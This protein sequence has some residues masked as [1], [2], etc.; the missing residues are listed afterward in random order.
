MKADEA[1]RL[2]TTRN[3]GIIAHI[4]AG[5]TT[6]SERILYYTGRTYKIGEV[7]DGAAVMDWMEQE[8][9]R[10]ITIT[11][12]A[13]TCQ[14][15]DCTINLIDTPGHVDFTVEV[16][17]SLRVL[18][19]AVGVFCAVGGVEP[20]SETVWRQGDTYKVPRLAF[21]NKMD[22]VGADFFRVLEMMKARLHTNP[23]PFQIPIGKEENFL[24]VIDLI[25]MKATYYDEQSLGA[26][27][28]EKDIPADMLP[29]ATE[30]RE[31]LVESIVEHDDEMMHHYLEG[32]EITSEE[33]MHAARAATLKL[34]ITPVLCGA[35]FKNKGV[36]H[37]LDAVVDYL[38]SPLDVPPVI[39]MIPGKEEITEERKASSEEPFTALAFKI[40]TDPYVGQLTYIRI[41][42]GELK[43]GTHIYNVRKSKKERV[44]R[45]LRMHSNKREEIESAA[46]GEI[47]AVLGLKF[48]TT[49]DT[50]TTEEHPITLESLMIPEPVIS[51]AVEPKT[52]DD[53][54]KMGMALAKLAVEDPSLRVS[55]D[56]ESGQTILAGMGEL[57]L[58]IIV[59]RMKREFGIVA[60]IGKPQ[61]AYRETVM[62][63][64]EA[65]YKHIKQSGGRGQYGHVWLKVENLG[66]GS[67]FE[68]ENGVVG[69]SIPR[70]YIPAV[71]KGVKEGMDSGGLAGYPMVDVKVTVFDGSYHDVD[72]SEI[73]FK[74]AGLQAFRK[75]CSAA[76]PILLEPIMKVD[77][78]VPDE[79]VGAVTGD[80]SGRRGHIIH[81]ER[82]GNL[83]AITSHIPLA[84]MFG[85]ATDVR[86]V[87]QG[88]ATY[89]M[90]FLKYQ[91][92]P[93]NISEEV[94]KKVKGT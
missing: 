23:V 51:I 66:K 33:V 45:M 26:T 16:E 9:E 14:W 53:Q 60:N 80:I 61:V 47:V 43:A 65:E 32:G 3:I 81:T 77:V 38:P 2:A 75:A 42:S 82:R 71:E 69:G 85:Y 89:S 29:L 46:A 36:Q 73:A 91:Q 1:K 5:K 37:L 64:A 74:I 52:R 6:V 27:L 58:E 63:M 87:T 35:A 12:A 22:R 72:S 83:Q 20:Q 18:D 84:N 55:T 13:T 92:A 59:D 28:V 94:I 34:A 31:K 8:Q 40:M 93:R 24:G 25:K 7:H 76:K 19:G 50:L 49:G 88:R 4:D 44:G 70:E 57:H 90:E 54:E 62:G 86:S 67:G 41:Y 11:S 10:G 56:P 17:R 68:F 78:V 48:T 15:K 79:Y 30:Y 21:V 39:G